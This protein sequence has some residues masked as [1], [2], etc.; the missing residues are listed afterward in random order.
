MRKISVLTV[1]TLALFCFT[2]TASSQGQNCSPPSTPPVVCTIWS[3]STVPGTIDGGDPS[4]GEY[5]V[6]FRSDSD[7]SV[8]GIRFYKSPANTGTH[9][10]NLW[11]TNGNL[12]ASA[13]VS[14]ESASGWQQFN[15]SAPVN[16][17]AGTTYIASY[18]TP[19]GHYSFDASYFNSAVDAAPLHALANT[20]S[21]NGVYNYGASSAFPASTYNASNYWADV[22]FI[23]NST[24]PPSI[25][26]TV[27][28]NGATFVSLGITVKAT[29]NDQ[30][31]SSTINNNTFFLVDSSNNNVPA[32]VT[33]D[34]STSIASLKPTAQ[35]Q[36]LT[37]YTATV[38]G[39]VQDMF[40]N[41]MGSDYSWSF[42]TGTA[43][44][45]GGPGGPVLVITSASNP[46]STYLGEILLAEGVNYFS[47]Q[48]ISTVTSAVLSAYDVAILG[49]M[50]LT[51][52]QVSMLS[53]W[54]NGGGNLIAMHPDKQLAGLLG[55]ISTTKSM[56]DDYLRVNTNTGPGVGIVNQ[57]IQYH[58]LADLY[59][60]NGASQLA[61]LYS[62]S[63]TATT[64]PAVTVVSAGS[65]QAAAFTYDLAR[66]VVYTRQGNPAWS[67]EQRDGYI[68]P[69]INR[70]VIR[71]DDLFYGNASFDP[72]PDWVDL[73]KVAIP[74]ADEQ[75]RFLVNLISQMNLAKK[76]LPRF[77]YLPSGFKAAVIMTGDD[78]NS[79]GSRPRFDTY[80]SESP[81][82]CSVADW[83]CVRATTYV[84]PL[85]PFSSYQLYIAQGFEIA[86]HSDNSP[87]CTDFTP[88]SLDAAITSQ[89]SA[90]AQNY[91]DNPPSQTN[92]THC[93]LWS[94]YDSEPQILLNHGMRLDTTYYYWP[95]VWMQ[96]VS[97]LFTGS[98]M[99]MRYSDRNGNIIDVY[100]ATTQIPDEDNWTY[101]DVVNTLIN[102]ALGP[103]GFYA[104]ITCNMHTDF[105][106]SPG[107]DAIVAA[108]QA[109]GV[110]VVSSLQMLT[111]L[112]GRNSSVFGSLLWNS[113]TLSFNVSVGTGARNLQAMVPVNS[114]VG[115]LTSITT[116]GTPV[117]YT[118]Q[119]IKGVQYAFFA[120]TTTAY[121]ATYGGAASF[122]ISGNI[123]GAGGSG[124]TVTLSGAANSTTTADGSG[125]YSF[126]NLANGSYTV[127][128]SSV[129]YTFTPANQNV[130]VSGAN[131]TG[132]NFSSAAATYSISG[133]ISGAGGSGATVTLSGAA[134]STTT[135]DGSGNY[136]FLN[137]A[138]GSYTVTP[139]S[140]GYTF[141]PANQ[142][143]TVSGANVTG[144]NFSSAA[145]T[146]SISGTISG[147]GGS[148]ATVKL[149]GAANSTTTADGSGNYSFSN[150]ANGSYTVT[151]SNVGYTFTPANQNVTVSGANVTG[152]NFSSAAA[153]TYFI[154]G[155]ISGPGGS[156]ATVKLSGAANST[157]T[158]DGSG[159]Y[160]FSN[161]A[162]GS[163]TVTP[164]SVGYTFTP[165]NQN[166]TVSG[167]NV[168]GV[169]FSSAAATTYFISGTISGPGGSGA[170]VK[171]SGAANS[172]TTADG[173]GNYSFSNLANGSYTV[174]P[175]NVGYTFSPTN[176][177]VTVS[178]ANV[179]GVNF[180]S[181]AATT[182][183]ISGTI[184][185]PGGSGATVKLS[186]AAN[187]TTTADGSGNYSFSNLANGSY[188]VTPSSV[189][190]TFTPAN[191]NVTVSGANVT[192]VNFT[193]VA[194]TPVVQLAPTSLSFG[195]QRVG[196][197]STA[198]TVTLT[199]TGTGILTISG[200]S[201]GGTNPADFTQTNNCGTSVAPGA[202]CAINVVFTP[203]ANGSRSAKL[204]VAD[205]AAGSPQSVG[206]SGTGISPIVKLSTTSINF[207]IVLDFKTSSTKSVTVR[208]TGNTTLNISSITIG[209]TNAGDFGISSKSCG[210][211]LAVSSTCTVSV[212]FTPQAAGTRTATLNFADDATNSPQ[213]VSLNGTGTMVKVSPNSLTF[214]SRTV[215]TTSGAKN[216]SLT[217]V[218]PGTL[219]IS[220]ITITGTNP[221]DFSQTNNC[222]ATLAMNSG[223]TIAVGFTPS[224]IG[225]RTATLRVDDSDP[226]SPE[227]ISLTGRGQ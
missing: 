207:G 167:A 17:L 115:S 46:F 158:A 130:T 72:E 193:S 57:T 147:A 70:T 131:V 133:T 29:F 175:S 65:G 174:T 16:I 149:S 71:P 151:P 153:T 98:G 12:L 22:L 19:T 24:T 185:G 99:P 23:P 146:Y 25:T 152:V 190:Y 43:P 183:F 14:G 53:N 187:S 142:N 92:R 139:S 18:F 95:D 164:S 27:P 20:T 93:V 165:A 49:D 144:V 159:N 11:A 2:M 108:A 109:A 103:L 219:T 177:N 213:S 113:N 3:A 104:V 114:S 156:G 192:G 87:T 26:S 188:T 90:M 209:G 58:G 6:K 83:Q 221:G 200:I 189:G 137:L 64:Y 102:N 62:S 155:T 163:Y 82:N 74:Q 201:F 106:T 168:T 157:T 135:A 154:S 38:K 91:P 127:T 86:T 75:Q 136:S 120:A 69:A 214:A 141:T 203:G 205:N 191:Q 8:T 97:G 226:T 132:V 50:T 227:L 125:N 179:T 61:T 180:S 161:L 138:N 181:A 40:G 105:P 195:N 225:T 129:G 101:P 30:I 171:L 33:Y 118:I 134:N 116:N 202:N 122:S 37:T 80:I 5:G 32:T 88:S 123:S 160:S 117:N 204:L 89:L 63:T 85:T 9:V 172:T 128:P 31:N 84:W 15:F 42:K 76:P 60:L 4:P 199:N 220:G 77:W 111:W 73:N 41:T 51:S 217:N 45:N 222:G 67:G 206:L 208:N 68:D 39:S 21:V 218:G 223:C 145:A 170:T 48:D 34:S 54:V 78:H 36:Q 28:A 110:P 196:I 184:S 169:N 197:A 121:Q 215:G 178:G 140:V 210:A 182:Y 35:L 100:Q 176:Q 59:T 112:D 194:G 143:V 47:E 55:L 124:A 79:G 211:T 166:V 173:S 119:T 198:Q 216:V 96:D 52:A 212:V 10:I 126:L 66:S 56:S 1:A 13:V 150:L 81:A 107:S 186:G 224:A 162:N 7:G 44:S 148:G 94:D